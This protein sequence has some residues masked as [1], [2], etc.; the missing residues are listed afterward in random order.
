MSAKTPR[1]SKG[2][3]EQMIEARTSAVVTAIASGLTAVNAHYVSVETLGEYRTV[4]FTAQN[5]KMKTHPKLHLPT[6]KC[7]KLEL[8]SAGIALEVLLH[9]L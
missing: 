5:E 6:T 4:R 1:K 9:T 7:A 3:N 2:K 8:I